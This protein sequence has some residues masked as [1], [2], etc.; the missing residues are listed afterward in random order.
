MQQIVELLQMNIVYIVLGF[1][2][3]NLLLFILIIILFM[4][5]AKLKKKYNEFMR[6]T[7]TDIEGLLRESIEKA[8]SIQE[9]HKYVK[10]SIARMQVQL[11]KCVQKVGIVRYGAIPGVGADLSFVVAL[12]DDSDNGVVVNGIYTRDGSYTYAKEI[13]TG[14]SKHTLSD[15]ENEAIAIAK[16]IQ[17][18]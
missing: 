15:E 4:K 13:V 8:T 17:E 12:L 14:K 10:D 6:G 18:V 1:T 7:E 5:N 9:S 11:D 16:Q 3:I 2:A